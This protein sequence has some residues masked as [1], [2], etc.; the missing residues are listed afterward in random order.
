[1][2]VRATTKE[3]IIALAG[4]SVGCAITIGVLF[5]TISAFQH[6]YSTS[7]DEFRSGVLFGVLALSEDSKPGMDMLDIYR[8]A[9]KKK[10]NSVEH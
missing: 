8:L 5:G 3:I 9:Q 2:Q 4:F 10:L 6:Q 1:M 7:R